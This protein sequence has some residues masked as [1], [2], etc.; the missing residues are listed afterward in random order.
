VRKL[1]AQ[2]KLEVR[3]GRY[4]DRMQE[5]LAN[6]DYRGA[7]IFALIQEIQLIMDRKAISTMLKSAL[8]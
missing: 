2:G 7:Q 1:F 6:A 8:S 3:K 5:E 4:K